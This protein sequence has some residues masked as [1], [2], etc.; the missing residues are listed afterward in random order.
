MALRASES[1]GIEE[2]LYTPSPSDTYGKEDFFTSCKR[3]KHLRAHF[4][5]NPSDGV[6]RVEMRTQSNNFIAISTDEYFQMTNNQKRINDHGLIFDVS[7][8]S[9]KNIQM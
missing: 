2:I 6:W 3:F 5:K 1:V 9:V 7:K 4:L 8:L